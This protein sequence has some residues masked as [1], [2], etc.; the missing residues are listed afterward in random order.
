M[1][2]L[3]ND[4]GWF[5]D[6][7]SLLGNGF[8]K[9]NPKSNIQVNLMIF[10][11]PL[12]KTLDN[13]LVVNL[14]DSQAKEEYKSL[15]MKVYDMQ[16]DFDSDDLEVCIFTYNL[17]FQMILDYT[18]EDLLICL[19]CGIFIWLYLIFHI[20]SFFVGSFA[21]I[22]IF[23]SIPLTVV[24]YHYIFGIKYFA[25]L[26]NLVIIIE[27]GI[28]ADDVFVFYDAWI[29]AKRISILR[30]NRDKRMAYTFRKAAKGM[31]VTSLTTM[32]SFLATSISSIV[33]IMTF[34]LFAAIIIP[35][36]YFLVV[37]VTPCYYIIYDIY[38][39]KRCRWCRYRL[40]SKKKPIFN[41]IILPSPSRLKEERS[42]NSEILE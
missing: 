28:G 19:M 15:V 36:N 8:T 23:M 16:Y 2:E 42:G 13:G 7:R 10:G 25:L 32:V 17:A 12:I 31:F 11:S 38:L 34:G 39:R 26:H 3:A 9:D 20:R 1:K 27:L 22:N 4:N 29:Q 33:P 40:R 30:K 24:V 41:Q 18:Y 5:N 35:I 21:M 14:T 37:T 6:H